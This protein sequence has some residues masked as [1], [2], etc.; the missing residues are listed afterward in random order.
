MWSDDRVPVQS[1]APQDR[2]M[3]RHHTARYYAHRV[4]ESLTTRVSK[5]IC[6][7]VLGLLFLIGIITF[8]LWLSLRPHR[9]RFFV[10]GFSIPNLGE[11][12]VGNSQIIYNVTA[13]N[14]N[15]NIGVYYDSM[16]VAV[17][18]NEDQSIGGSPVLFPFYQEP[19]NTTV[20]A[21]VLGGA[22]L[23][24]TGQQWQQMVADLARGEVVF[25]IEITSVIRFKISSW[26]SK[27]H[28]MHANCLVHVGPDG[29][30]LPIYRD[31]R[32]PVYFG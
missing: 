31:K 24:A 22:A 13:R 9:P 12:G 8:I 2:T 19:K 30:I 27:R 28:R 6:A 1:T 32:C 20:I 14:S 16:Q 7:V 25:R 3:K 4:K 15:Q 17:F 23:T 29:S 18:Y 11:A 21:G 5:L 26:D 10:Q